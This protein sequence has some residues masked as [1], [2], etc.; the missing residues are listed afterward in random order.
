MLRLSRCVISDAGGLT[1]DDATLVRLTWAFSVIAPFA[2]C[3][4]DPSQDFS[5][6]PDP[7][8]CALAPMLAVPLLSPLSLPI[9]GD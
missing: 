3:A 7:H 2:D 1:D 4:P 5:H 8:A 6:R 9:A